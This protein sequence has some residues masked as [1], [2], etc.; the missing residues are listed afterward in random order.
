MSLRAIV[1][2]I[3]MPYRGSKEE[4]SQVL[5]HLKG[6]ASKKDAQSYHYMSFLSNQNYT[7]CGG[8]H[9]SSECWMASGVSF[10]CGQQGHSTANCPQMASEGQTIHQTRSGRSSLPVT[11]QRIG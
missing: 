5:S 4:A 7:V 1:I 11:S 10:K 3:I 9:K 6:G 2:R 8:R